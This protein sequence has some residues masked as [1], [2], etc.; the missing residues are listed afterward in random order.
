MSNFTSNICDS[1]TER[2]EIGQYILS[3]KNATGDWDTTVTKCPKEI[4]STLLGGA[5]AD[6]AGLGASLK[7]RNTGS[8]FLG[9]DREG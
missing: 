8:N 6:V 2:V 3:A 7:S 5:D 1:F 4:C 9:L